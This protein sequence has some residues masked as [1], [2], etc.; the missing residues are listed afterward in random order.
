MVKQREAEVMGAGLDHRENRQ[1][2]S[3]TVSN[4]T[5]SL[6][7]SIRPLVWHSGGE[8]QQGHLAKG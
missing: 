6:F 3:K 2:G 1:Y 4:N 8:K 5:G 7:V